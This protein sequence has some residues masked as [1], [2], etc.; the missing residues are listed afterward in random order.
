MYLYFLHPPETTKRS[1]GMINN[2]FITPSEKDFTLL[3][4]LAIS[5]FHSTFVAQ[6]IEE[7]SQSKSYF[8]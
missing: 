8:I 1:V 3:A 7:Q 5:D 6:F 2:Y 4:E